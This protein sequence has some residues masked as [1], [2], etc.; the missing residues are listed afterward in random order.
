MMVHRLGLAWRRHGDFEHAHEF[1]FKNDAMAVRRGLYRVVAV[2][3]SGFV[4]CVKIKM[5][6]DNYEC[7]RDYAG[8]IAEKRGRRFGAFMARSIVELAWCGRYRSDSRSI[9][10]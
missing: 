10:A 5:A 6:G 9:G 4:L 8:Q 1:V 7:D 2:W 3:E